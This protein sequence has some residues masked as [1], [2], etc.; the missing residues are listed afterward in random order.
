MTETAEYRYLPAAGDVVDARN[1]DDAEST[2]LKIMRVVFERNEALLAPVGTS[3]D[4]DT[5]PGEWWSLDALTP[6]NTSDPDDPAN[7]AMLVWVY[8]EDDQVSVGQIGAFADALAFAGISDYTIVAL[9]LSTGGKLVEISYE[10]ISSGY[11]DNDMASVTVKVALPNDR[12]ITG[13]YRVDGR[14]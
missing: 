9:Y 14:V 11:D 8:S 7:Q 13:S 2:R 1:I 12:T 3:P 6:V 5:V 4:D 10:T